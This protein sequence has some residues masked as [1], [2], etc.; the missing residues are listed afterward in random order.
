MQVLLVWPVVRYI[1]EFY[2]YLSTPKDCDLEQ[3]FNNL[4]KYEIFLHK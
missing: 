3:I 2:K 4:K 1:S